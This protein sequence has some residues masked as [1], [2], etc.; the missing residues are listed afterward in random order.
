V[1]DRLDPRSLSRA[2]LG[3]RRRADRHRGDGSLTSNVRTFRSHRATA[4]RK[5]LARKRIRAVAVDGKTSRGARRADGTRVHL[6]GIVEHGGR[7]LDHLQV[8]AK[9]S[10]VTHFT[11]LLTGLDLTGHSIIFNALHTVRENLNWLVTT[12]NAHYVEVIKKNQPLLYDAVKK[13]PWPAIPTGST[14]REIGHGRIE[15]RT[16]KTVHIDRLGIDFPHARQA[17]KLTR[18]RQ[19]QRTGKIQRE[20]VH[21][22]TS[23]TSA[24]ANPDDLVF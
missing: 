13:L 22:I 12:E 15:T 2:L 11:D 9:H 24:Q 17:V 18:W 4:A 7:L 1:L 10:E 19:H 8:D 5:A 3:S 20:T 23:L 21:V 16:L 14:T 6:L